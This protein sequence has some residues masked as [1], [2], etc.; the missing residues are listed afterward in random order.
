MDQ[1]MVNLDWGTAYYRDEV[2]LLGKQGE[3]E[4]NADDLAEWAGTISYEVFTNI[5]SRVPRVYV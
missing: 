2:I 3:S 1:I 5:N 4:I